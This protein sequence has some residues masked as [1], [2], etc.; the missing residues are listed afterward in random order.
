MRFFSLG[1]T[2]CLIAAIGF[3][4]VNICLRSLTLRCDPVSILLAKEAITF[5]V[6]G[7]WVLFYTSPEGR[8]LPRPRTVAVLATIGAL[9]HLVATLPWL[10]AMAVVGLAVAVTA[11]LCTSLV[12]TAALGRWLLKE[13]IST[14]SLMAMGL[15]LGAVVLLTSGTHDGPARHSSEAGGGSL[16]L[17]LAAAAACLA[18][19]IYGVLN[20]AVRHSV[21]RGVSLAFVAL[22]APFMGVVC[23]GPLCGTL[24]AWKGLPPIAQDD[25]VLLLTGGMLNAA[26][27]FAFVKGLQKIAAVHANLLTAS[28][29]GIAA[30]AGVFLFGESLSPAAMTGVAMTLLGIVCIDSSSA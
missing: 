1:F 17:W 21:S 15:L 11:T 3:S 14:R 29:A 4:G 9:T 27:W 30:L 28:Q 13:R 23:L 2:Y 12:T 22:V 24:A 19:V 8:S 26:A 20:V 25:V 5:V 7:L 10:W 18:G 16:T 6:I